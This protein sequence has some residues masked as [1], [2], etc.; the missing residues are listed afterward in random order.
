M[1]EQVSQQCKGPRLVLLWAESSHRC[2]VNGHVQELEQQQRLSLGRHPGLVQTLLDSSRD[3]WRSDGIGEV[4]ELPEQGTHRQVWGGAAVGQAVTFAVCHRLFSQTVREFCQ[5][6]G[7]P[8]A[9]LSRD[10][11]HLPLPT[12]GLCKARV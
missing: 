11:D 3:R 10:A 12:N 5:Q 8:Q 7:L 9:W 4:P 6:P 1:P 2:Q